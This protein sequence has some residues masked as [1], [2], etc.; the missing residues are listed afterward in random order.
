[1]FHKP[2]H[3]DLD[4]KHWF[5]VF[6]GEPVIAIGFAAVALH[7]ARIELNHGQTL[8]QLNA[9]GGLDWYELWC[10]FQGHPLSPSVAVAPDEAR[11]MV[12]SCVTLQALERKLNG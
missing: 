6:K 11:R 8:E 10:G 12:L 2:R 7:R 5:A 4:P 3:R 1:M 9:A